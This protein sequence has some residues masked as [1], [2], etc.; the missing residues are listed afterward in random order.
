LNLVDFHRELFYNKVND[1]NVFIYSEDDIRVTPKT[2]VAYLEQTKK[3]EA[4][5]GKSPAEDF[6]VGI[7]RYEYNYPP[8][9]IIDDKSR[10][11]TTNVTRVYWEHSN[12]PVIPNALIGASPV[13][14]NNYVTMKNHHQGMFIATKE[15]L[16]AWKKRP[17]CQ[18]D[19][20]R[21]RPGARN[22]PSQPSEGTQRVWMSSHML[23]GGRHCNVQQILPIDTF[24][25]LNVLHLPNKNYRRVGKKGRIGGTESAVENEFGNGNEQFNGPSK[26]LVTA[27]ETHLAMRKEFPVKVSTKYTGIVMMDEVDTGKFF[28]NRKAHQQLMNQ[29]MKAYEDYVKRG[30]VMSDS[31]FVTWNWID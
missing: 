15:L 22:N 18:F 24:G 14:K 3:V 17:G 2:V 21:Q 16:L 25:Q 13:L 27:M 19:V 28:Q 6:N 7:V 9:I 29:R 10:H 4:I 8:D 11:A 5:V 30:G 26:T 23:H 12:R 20:I 1:Y 31:D